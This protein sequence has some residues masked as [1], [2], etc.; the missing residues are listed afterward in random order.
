MKKAAKKKTTKPRIT[1]AMLLGRISLLESSLAFQDR[2]I[3][4]LRDKVD[5]D[6]TQLNELPRFRN[7]LDSIQGTVD[8]LEMLVRRK[9][10]LDVDAG[11]AEAIAIQKRDIANAAACQESPDL[12]WIP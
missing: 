8:K 9:Y 3:R 10:Q 4:R 5:F 1:L 6:N 12:T 7:Q 2:D 11:V